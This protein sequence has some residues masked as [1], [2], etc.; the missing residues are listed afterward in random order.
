M[1]TT[2]GVLLTAESAP[3]WQLETTPQLDERT[4]ADLRRVIDSFSRERP[5][6]IVIESAPL[7]H[8]G[9]G[10]KTALLL[11]VIASISKALDL[12]M[13]AQEIQVLSGRGG[14]SGVGI[15][16]FFTGGFLADAGHPQHTIESLLPSSATRPRR[17]PDLNVRVDIP[18]R[19]RFHL[20]LP[21]GNVR[22]GP[23][24]IE[25]F[26]HNT[27]VPKAEVHESIA[28]LYH[29]LVPGVRNSDLGAVGRALRRVHEVGFKKRELAGQSDAVKSS[30]SLLT[31]SID[32]PV[33]LSS[34]GP[35][36]YIIGDTEDTKLE[37][38]IA[39]AIREAMGAYAC[40]YL[41]SFSG[42]NSGHS[43]SV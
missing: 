13:T 40:I 19:W 3:T 22:A 43:V 31:A 24:E 10:S 21:P 33:G 23:P 12:E 9:L 17:L 34:M 30:F 5:L 11:A 25:F 7:Q 4:L 16:G 28:L 14:T 36:L 6:R 8:V 15:H 27:P 42:C 26:R 20:L 35:L 1:I 39:A 38:S 2:P 29:D 37:S 32:A 41:G 18:S